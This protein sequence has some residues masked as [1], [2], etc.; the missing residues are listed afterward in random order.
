MMTSKHESSNVNQPTPIIRSVS[1]GPFETNAYVVTVPSSTECWIVDPGM[2][3][4]P[5]LNLVEKEGLKPVAILLTHAHVDHIAGLDKVRSTFGEMP[6]YLHRAEENWCSTP[7]L[8]LSELMGL[9]VSVREPTNW[10]DGGE[11]LALVGTSW[12]VV[13]T[14]GHSPGGVCYLHEA[15]NQAIVGDTLFAG[16]IGRIDFPTSHPE[17]MRHSLLEVLMKWPDVVTIYP[18]HGPR[19]TIGAEREANPYIRFGF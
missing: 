18:G 6:V 17:H 7:M 4:E 2:E 15:S 13:H 10:L 1:L 16:S 3:P 5:L 8:N 9:P 14:P 11:T 12:R 19:T